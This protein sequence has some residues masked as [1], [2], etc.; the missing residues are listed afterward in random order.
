[1]EKI[2]GTEL[3]RYMNQISGATVG[4]REVDRLKQQIPNLGM[5]E[6]QFNNAIND[7]S[8]TLQSTEDFLYKNNGFKDRNTFYQ[9]AGA[10]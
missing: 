6:E 9:V 1:M 4:D 3:S 7:Y 10:G 8:N 2:L 5:N